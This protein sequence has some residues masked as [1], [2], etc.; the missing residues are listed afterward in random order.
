MNP[1]RYL[2]PPRPF[3]E[4]STSTTKQIK[5]RISYVDSMKANPHFKVSEE[6]EEALLDYM[7]ACHI[8][9]EGSP[10]KEEL[11]TAQTCVRQYEKSLENNGPARLSFDLATKTKLGEELD[12]L[13][14]M[15]TFTR[16]EKYLPEDV[17][18]Q[19]KQHPSSQVSDPWHKTFWRPFY[20]RLE[21][22]KASF[23]K[24]LIGQNYHNECPTFL[25]LALLCER[26]TLDWDET[27]QLIQV[28]ATD[29][30]KVEPPAVDLVD[31]L[32]RRDMPGLATRLDRDEASISL[33]AEYV[34]GVGSLVLAFFAS[35]LPEF[36]F[37]REEVDPA[38]WTP[39]DPL[40]V[41]FDLEE[42]HEQAFRFMMQEMFNKMAD[43]ELDDSDED[44][45]DDWDND[46][47]DDDDDIA[48][49]DG[50]EDY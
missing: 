43:G 28:C 13:W 37:D 45:Y 9:A 29:G 19:A 48:M 35:H 39:K 18:E 38:D 44:V 24:V 21:A 26:H 32:K 34:M 4:I 27:I 49:S 50:S 12:N 11:A 8:L 7:E 1:L 16:Y 40:L 31:F 41:L 25:L 17:M 6:S 36:L 15:W 3:T 30:D 33:S 2:A 46:D 10:S 5:E 42:A 20:G 14:D 47:D 22:E 23:D